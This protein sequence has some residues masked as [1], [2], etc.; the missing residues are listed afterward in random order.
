MKAHKLAELLLSLPDVE[1]KH[2]WDGEART[3][4]QHV[5]LANG[6]FIATADNDEPVYYDE[7]RP[8]N[9][10]TEAEDSYWHF[11]ES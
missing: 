8:E 6:G 9:A 5:W 7:D 10:P 3:T 1:V 4:I 2:V 11:G